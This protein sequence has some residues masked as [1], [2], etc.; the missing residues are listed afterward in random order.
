MI[1]QL[2]RVWRRVLLM[3]SRARVTLVDDS[4]A[5]QFVQAQIDAFSLLDGMPRLAEYGF[6]SNPPPGADLAV[7]F[8]GGNRSD[9]VAVAT[10]HQT[11]RLRNLV[12]GEVAISDN[13][14]Q[15]VYLSTAGIR[16]EG[17][18]LPI[19][20]DTT[21]TLTINAAGGIAL[22]APTLAVNANTTFTG[23]MHANG[24]VIDQTHHHVPDS[25]GDTQGP[26]A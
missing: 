24:K 23:T 6:Q 21:S 26:V 3:V 25:H 20:I 17:A 10:G 5:V 4:N 18:G 12:S 22:N 15:K 11:Y 13:L 16:I 7:I 14:G 2:E 1:E 9:G 19:Q 8:L